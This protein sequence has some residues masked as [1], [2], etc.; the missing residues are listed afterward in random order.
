MLKTNQREKRETNSSLLLLSL[1]YNMA[2]YLFSLFYFFLL[3]V[4]KDV[5]RKQQNL[6]WKKVETRKTKGKC[7]HL[8]PVI[9]CTSFISSY[10]ILY[11]ILFFILLRLC[12]ALFVEINGSSWNLSNAYLGLSKVPC[13][14]PAGRLGVS[15]SKREGCNKVK[16]MLKI[17]WENGEMKVIF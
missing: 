10:L 2:N 12:F 3:I 14:T 11:T 9:L 17:Q 5:K 13:D 16:D 7:F 15:K 4:R 1:P 8:F 6:P